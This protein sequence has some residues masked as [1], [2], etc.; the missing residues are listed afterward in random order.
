MSEIEWSGEMNISAVNGGTHSRSGQPISHPT[1]QP[2]Q[3]V[4]EKIKSFPIQVI[5]KGERLSVYH[6]DESAAEL[7]AILKEAGE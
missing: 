2:D 6:S 7:A 4:I 3:R 5:I 1:R